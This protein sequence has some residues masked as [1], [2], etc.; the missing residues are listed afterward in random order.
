MQCGINL[1]DIAV[2]LLHMYIGSAICTV[3]S[4]VR[5]RVN[6]TTPNP[7]PNLTV[8]QTLTHNLTQTYFQPYSKLRIC[9]CDLDPL[10]VPHNILQWKMKRKMQI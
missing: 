8:T 9:I 3:R 2:S 1:I 4:A 7:D 6:N 10:S 5:Y